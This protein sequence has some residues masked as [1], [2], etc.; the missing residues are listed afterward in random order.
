MLYDK[1]SPI[2]DGSME[3]KSLGVERLLHTVSVPCL[4]VSV[5]GLCYDAVADRTSL[6]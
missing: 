1:Q 6:S 4:L 3:I 5:D 2:S